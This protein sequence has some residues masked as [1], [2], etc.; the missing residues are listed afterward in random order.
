MEA[1]PQHEGHQEQVSVS[2]QEGR[3][4]WPKCLQAPGLPPQP[5]PPS[6]P[7]HLCSP[8]QL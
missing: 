6:R 7:P 3:M 5:K 8:E 4:L 1:P 2:Q